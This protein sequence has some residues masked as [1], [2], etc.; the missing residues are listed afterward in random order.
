MRN[1]SLQTN[2]C[3]RV[4]PMMMILQISWSVA[5]ARHKM[6][7]LTKVVEPKLVATHHTGLLL[8]S[9]QNVSLSRW[10]TGS[11]MLCTR[12]QHKTGSQAVL[13]CY[14]I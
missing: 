4:V 10:G 5:F 13:H 9:V 7:G 8:G 14:T 11:S 2:Y 3:S 12:R 1:I 6:L